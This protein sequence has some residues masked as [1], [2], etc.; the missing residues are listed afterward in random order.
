MWAE[1]RR[2]EVVEDLAAAA[3]AAVM[4]LVEVQ[5]L[6]EPENVEVVEPSSQHLLYRCRRPHLLERRSDPCYQTVPQ[7]YLQRASQA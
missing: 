4:V 2:K 6:A 3:A 7:P 1:N 5:P